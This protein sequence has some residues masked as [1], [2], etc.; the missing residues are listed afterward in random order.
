MPRYVYNATSWED[1]QRDY[2]YGVILILPPVEVSDP[3]NKL[4]IEYDPKSAVISP[5]HISV[6]DPLKVEMTDEL[7]QEIRSILSNIEPFELYFDKPHASTARP[8]VAYPILPQDPIDTMKKALHKASVFGNMAYQRRDI[9]AHMTIAE[10]ISIE[11]GLKIAEELKN[12][13][14]SGSFLCDRLELIIPDEQFRFQRQETFML[15]E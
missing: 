1:W 11:E 14:P 4:R 3:I 8:G 6:S 2:R 7:R 15:G 12:T 13:A 10:F 9:P 5:A